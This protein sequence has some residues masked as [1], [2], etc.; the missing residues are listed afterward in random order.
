MDLS[1]A[2]FFGSFA[3][4]VALAMD[5]FSV[6]LADGLANPFMKRR[7]MTAIAGIF[8][9]FQA[10]MPLI[11]WF[12]VHTVAERFEIFERAVP[13]IALLLLGFLGG[14][15]LFEGIRCRKEQVC[16][17]NKKLT[18]GTLLAQGVATSIDA[19]SEGVAISDY[20]LPEAL[21]CAFI[22]AAVTF[23]ICLFG[24]YLGKKG[25]SK[26]SGGA[27]ILGGSI[28]V[29]IGLWIFIKSFL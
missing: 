4:G 1:F 19:L 14:K 3:M 15:M 13:Y 11:G 24:V 5:A 8:A 26:F 17:C 29:F 12:L 7:K 21:L 16:A 2:F 22:I 20:N 27:G 10:L 23:V 25:G 9:F 28:L 18:L 6:S